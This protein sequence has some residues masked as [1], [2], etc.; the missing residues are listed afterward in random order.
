MSKRDASARSVN[1]RVGNEASARQLARE[2]GFVAYV[3]DRLLFRLGRSSQAEDFFLKGGVLVANLV[4]EPHRFTRDVDFLRRHGPPSADDIRTRFE[5]IL[6]I[7]ADDGITF[8]RVRATET[9]RAVDEYDGVK[10]VIEATVGGRSVEV[11]VDVGFGDAVE[12]PVER[13]KLAPFLEDDP[14]ATVYAYQAE[15]VLAEKIETIL[16]KFPLVEH[17]L[18]DVLDVVVLSDRLVFEGPRLVA[19]LGSTFARRETP[20]DPQ[21]LDEILVK[22]TGRKWAARWSTMLRDKAVGTPM[23]L[24]DAVARFDRFVR[25]LLIGLD[26]GDAPRFWPAAGP[27][28]DAPPEE[29]ME[30]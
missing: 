8:G 10:L 22:I 18:K 24:P 29:T 15:T 21:V 7:E 17:R 12:P 28:M 11:R 5:L 26:G 25:P 14:P 27:W 16:K 20:A 6:A 30:R 1:Q 13:R 4:D 2:D 19:A 23:P 9:D 3:M